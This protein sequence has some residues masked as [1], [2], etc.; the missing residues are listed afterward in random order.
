MLTLALLG[1]FIIILIIAVIVLGIL[2]YIEIKYIG[3]LREEMHL[4]QYNIEALCKTSLFI[5]AQ[6]AHTLKEVQE[7]KARKDGKC[8]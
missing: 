3:E 5:D 7:A 1:D 6:E 8:K 2:L 4:M